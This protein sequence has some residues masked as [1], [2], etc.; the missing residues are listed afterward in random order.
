MTVDSFQ[1]SP[2]NRSSS[3]PMD[4]DNQSGKSYFPKAAQWQRVVGV[5]PPP[6]QASFI[7]IDAKL[8]PLK[9]LEGFTE[10]KGLAISRLSQPKLEWL[11][12]FPSLTCLC[13][14]TPQITSLVTLQEFPNLIA[15]EL[16]DPP[17][18]FGLGRVSSLECLVLR[19]FRKIKSLAPIGEISGLRVLSLST[20]P[21]WDASRRCLEVDSLDPLSNL[22]KLESLRM[23]GVKPIDAR[24]D[25]LS[26]LTQ[27]R[28]LHI[29]HEFQFQLE[30]YAALARC[31][32]STSG[33]CLA[34]YYALP[35]LSLRCKRCGGEIVFLTGPRP[36]TRRQLCPICD[37]G[38]LQDHERRWGEIAKIH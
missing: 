2:D 30:D 9:I 28:Y 36:R 34:P 8:S 16:D 13:L 29:S 32:P 18:L 15:L 24:L 22:A 23:I 25:P 6:S 12:R 27:L 21:S 35:Q 31:L 1:D 7:R 17:T 10:I 11:S 26:R 33:H 20:I 3:K 14:I 4:A 19:H 38:K 5:Q 37:K